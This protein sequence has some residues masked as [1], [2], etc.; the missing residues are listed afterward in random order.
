MFANCII[1]KTGGMQLAV[2]FNG[3]T[4]KKLTE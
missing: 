1:N 2:V 3:A 4:P